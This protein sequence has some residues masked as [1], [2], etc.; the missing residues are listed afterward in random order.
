MAAKRAK[1]T[2]KV[3]LMAKSP[4][5][6]GKKNN[7]DKGAFSLASRFS[8][9]QLFM[10]AVV[11][12]VIGGY[13]IWRSY[14]ASITLGSANLDTQRSPGTTKVTETGRG[15]RNTEVLQIAGGETSRATI[16]KSIGAGNYKACVY[17]VK[18][19]G[20]PAGTFSAKEFTTNTGTD[21]GS[22]PLIVNADTSKYSSMACLEFN[23][24]VGDSS[25]L[26][27]YV[28]NTAA[29]SALRVSYIILTPKTT[30]PPPA[31]VHGKDI[32]ASNTGVPARTTLTARG[33]FTITQSGEYSNLDINGGVVIQANNVT[34]RNSRIRYSQTGYAINT[35]E[36]SYSGILLENVEIDGSGG[37]N[38]P[39]PGARGICCS[40]FTARRVHI[41][42]FRS[43][44][45]MRSDA[46]VEYSYIHDTWQ[47]GTNVHKSGIGINGY[48]N[49]II[50]GNN[51]DV[52][53]PRVSAA[54]AMYGDFAVVNNAL[55]E[56]NLFNTSGGYCSY[57]GSVQNPDPKP[58]PVAT[59]VRFFNNAYGKKYWPKCGQY[60]TNAAFDANGTGNQW[61]GNYWLDTGEPVLPQ[62]R[63]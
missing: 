11:F 21:L 41:H 37:A 61:S 57:G 49:F 52:A 5:R 16:S 17:G 1:T 23:H 36:G 30:T 56:N 26:A 15:K 59:N 47:G 60:G 20:S 24:Q 18:Q 4:A 29:N 28:T 45:I 42:G 48:S 55:V 10:F 63:V 38:L 53:G 40:G 43:G 12:A 14:A 13:F 25:V 33:A 6:S 51:I 58:F 39:D 46:T 54:L 8:F 3:T 35:G 50:R 27:F 44:V 62:L 22:K 32:N 34:I 2:R 31:G 9:R 7:K 19:S